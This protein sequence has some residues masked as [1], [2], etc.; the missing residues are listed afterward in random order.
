MG[1]FPLALTHTSIDTIIGNPNYFSQA[2]VIKGWHTAALG[3]VHL[4]GEAA[5]IEWLLPLDSFQG[6]PLPALLDNLCLE[7]GL[8]G[9]KF[10]TVSTALD[11]CLFETLRHGGFCTYGWERFWEMKKKSPVA[12]AGVWRRPVE[13]DHF[14]LA[15]LQKRLLPPA[16]QTITKPS[17][18]KPPD[19]ILRVKGEI[20]GFANCNFYHHTLV[21]TPLF[22]PQVVD[23]SAIILSFFKKY[24]TDAQHIFIRQTSAMAWLEDH[25][26]DIAHPATDRLE[27]LVK[28]FAVRKRLS[29]LELNH[30]G[31]RRHTDPAV[32][33]AHSFDK[34]DHL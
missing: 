34:Q 1:G 6:D 3:Q 24:F 32:P 25:L 13:Q 7:S 15:K 26:A 30:A 5:Q 33:F 20:A 17:T 23:P 9:V 10:L 18:E 27:L 14:T 4:D 31:D 28:H 16:V 21:F 12:D 22:S 29:V 19:F 11:D 2:L 8:R